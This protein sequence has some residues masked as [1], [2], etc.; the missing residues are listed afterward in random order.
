[1]VSG[2]VYVSNTNGVGGFFLVDVLIDGESVSPDQDAQSFV[3]AVG[4]P[5]S[6]DSN[7]NYWDR[8]TTIAY[9]VTVPVSAGVHNVVQKLGQSAQTSADFLDVSYFY[10]KN[11]LT[12]QYYPESQASLSSSLNAREGETIVNSFGE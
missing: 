2:S 6:E 11:Y 5:G 1:M 10:N 7:S 9:T 8:S 4:L 3:T 12:A